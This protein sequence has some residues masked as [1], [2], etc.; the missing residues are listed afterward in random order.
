MTSGELGFVWERCADEEETGG[1]KCEGEG[2]RI[3]RSEDQPV[4]GPRA[5]FYLALFG[6]P[7]LERSDREAGDGVSGSTGT[8]KM[9]EVAREKKASSWRMAVAAAAQS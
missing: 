9:K 7:Y 3:G 5:S 8:G 6:G 2:L 4:L 1:C